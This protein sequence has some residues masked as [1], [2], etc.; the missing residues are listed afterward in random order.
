MAENCDATHSPI[1]LVD[2][3]SVSDHGTAFHH[4]GGAFPLD[5]DSS[6]GEPGEVVGYHAVL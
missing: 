5:A 3:D 1:V 4:K 2:G 6:P